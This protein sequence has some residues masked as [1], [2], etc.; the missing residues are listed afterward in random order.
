[1]HCR[2]YTVKIS[3][4]TTTAAYI[5]TVCYLRCASI[6]CSRTIYWRTRTKQCAIAFWERPVTHQCAA[7]ASRIYFRS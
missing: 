2:L 4:G 6:L 5:Q 3:A 7:V 1:M